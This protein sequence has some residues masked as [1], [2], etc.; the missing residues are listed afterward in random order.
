MWRIV[1]YFPNDA[2]KPGNITWTS[3]E[4][5][6]TGLNCVDEVKCYSWFVFNEG[7]VRSGKSILHDMSPL[8]HFQFLL[9][10]RFQMSAFEST[11]T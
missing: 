11:K 3:T 8:I 4:E 9:F 6:E 7:K 2:I 10:S 5:E 1:L